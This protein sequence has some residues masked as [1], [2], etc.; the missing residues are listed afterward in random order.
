MQGLPPFSF[1]LQKALSPPDTFSLSLATPWTPPHPVHPVNYL[2]GCL[3]KAQGQ[4]PRMNP[5]FS[6]CP[7]N[8]TNCHCWPEKADIASMALYPHEYY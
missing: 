3:S 7:L 2:H 8:R 1:L 6:E 5:T 4:R